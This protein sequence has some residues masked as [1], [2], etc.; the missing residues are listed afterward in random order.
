[1]RIFFLTVIAGIVLW[2]VASRVARTTDGDGN[3]ARQT[4]FALQDAQ[5]DFYSRHGRYAA[6]IA[7]LAPELPDGQKDGY[8]FSIT[9]QGNSYTIRAEPLYPRAGAH[10]LYSDETLVIRD[11][12][13][14]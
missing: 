12:P 2:F 9:T 6:S 1:M 13:P 4:I 10:T 14:Q 7:E 8:R 3:A 5:V 11:T